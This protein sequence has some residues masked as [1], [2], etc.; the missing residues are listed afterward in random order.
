MTDR[1]RTYNSECGVN[2]VGDRHHWPTAFGGAPRRPNKKFSTVRRPVTGGG[3]GPEVRQPDNG[4]FL[5]LSTSSSSSHSSQSLSLS[6]TSS[7]PSTHCYH[8]PFR[9]PNPKNV[10]TCE[11]IEWEVMSK[12]FARWAISLYYIYVYLQ[13]TTDYF[14]FSKGKPQTLHHFTWWVG[15]WVGWITFKFHYRF[16][17]IWFRRYLL[18]TFYAKI[19]Q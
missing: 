1:F 6:S 18:F 13:A 19:T 5:S 14:S 9:R 8:E 7:T 4:M 17:V 12:H 16:V 2:G 15:G 3:E 10:E 11:A